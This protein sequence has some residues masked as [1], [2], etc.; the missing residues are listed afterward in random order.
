LP[1]NPD[2]I[3]IFKLR[4]MKAKG[5]IQPEAHAPTPAPQPVSYEAQKVAKPVKIP[6][7]VESVKAEPR[8]LFRRKPKTKEAKRKE[9]EEVEPQPYAEERKIE[10]VE[11][12]ERSVETEYMPIENRKTS[13]L[14]RRESGVPAALTGMIFLFNAFVFAYFIY[15]QSV[16][17]IGYVQHIG[18][19]SFVNST[20]YYYDVSL[21]N[22][23]LVAFTALTG[24]LI[25]FRARG[26]HLMAG[27]IG[28]LVAF[29]ATYQYLNSNANYFLIV[30]LIS[31]I[32]IGSLVYSR[33]AAVSEATREI[34]PEEVA[35]P[36]PE[37][38]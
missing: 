5:V 24:L 31:F 16:F 32:G 14:Y 12:L 7:A 30:S 11:N 2:E 35:W 36:M 28:S 38:F 37:T 20:N 25:V 26:S 1:V 23:G 13:A 33:M 18:I 34:K 9:I 10:E 4:G 29:A 22:I 6:E 15:P 27:M 3:L 17:V 19:N 21:M 8:G